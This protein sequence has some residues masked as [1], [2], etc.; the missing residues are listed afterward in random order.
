MPIP[1][2]D[3]P[4]NAGQNL[5]RAARPKLDEE[6]DRLAEFTL[7]APRATVAPSSTET[8]ASHP[9]GQS[10]FPHPLDRQ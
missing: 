4:T 2:T 3:S 5:D 9:V 8:A 10:R 7:E 1:H 6:A